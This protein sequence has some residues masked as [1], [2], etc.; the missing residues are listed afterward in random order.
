MDQIRDYIATNEANDI[1]TGHYRNGKHNPN[2]MIIDTTN[3]KFEGE[4]L[5]GVC[6]GKGKEFFQFN[7][8]ETISFQGEFFNG[9]KTRFGVEYFD[10][11]LVTLANLLIG[12]QLLV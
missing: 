12:P 5:N 3:R 7:N 11:S 10:F 6:H 4:Y 1:G 2:N 9:L 8:E